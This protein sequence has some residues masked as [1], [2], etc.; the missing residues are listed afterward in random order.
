MPCPPPPQLPSTTYE[1]LLEGGPVRE[2]VCGDAIECRGTDEEEAFEVVC[3]LQFRNTFFCRFSSFV[4]FV[5]EKYLLSAISHFSVQ[6]GCLARGLACTPPPV[7]PPASLPCHPACKL[8]S[9]GQSRDACCN[10][11]PR[12]LDATCVVGRPDGHM[13]HGCRTQAPCHRHN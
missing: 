6:W 12:T 4:T 3:R 5:C 11:S 7:S 1:C 13:G 10:G 9:M 8:R 2:M